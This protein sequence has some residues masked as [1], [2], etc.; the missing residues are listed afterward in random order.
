MLDL[1]S[2]KYCLVLYSSCLNL[3]WVVLDSC[4]FVLQVAAWMLDTS[5]SEA[6]LELE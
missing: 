2:L 3:Y 1:L 6:E 5:L 4:S